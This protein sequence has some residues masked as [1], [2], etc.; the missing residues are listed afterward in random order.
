MSYT[1][2]DTDMDKYDDLEELYKLERVGIK[3]GLDRIKRLLNKLGNPQDHYKIVHVGGTNGKGS[4]CRAISSILLEG[5]YSVGLYTSPHLVRLNER[6]VVDGKEIENDEL[7]DISRKV[8]GIVRDMYEKPTFFEITTAIAFEFFRMKEID[9]AVVEVGM[10]G[11][12]DATNVVSPTL[13]IIT[14]VAIDH[15]DYLGNS[16]ED[17]AR[18][19]AGIIKCGI[20]VITSAKGK[21]LDIIRS[22][23]RS[24]DAELITVDGRWKRT[25]FDIVCQR[26][27]VNGILRDYELESR[28]LG[29]FQGENIALSVLAAEKLQM[30]G[31]FLPDKSIEAGIKNTLNPGRMEFISRSP[32][33][34]IDGAHNV[35][36][37]D[38]LTKSLKDFSYN[39]LIVVLGILRDKDI[40]G[41]VKKISHL[42]EHII[43]TMPNSERAFDSEKLAE[44]VRR[45]N[46]KCEVHVTR[47]V[48]DA[49]EMAKRICKN[50][51]LICVTGSL[52]TV[53]EV[54]ATIIS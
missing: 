37:M 22:V 48:K 43:T 47:N 50:D 9:I 23:A 49:I 51:D 2:R 33:I 34:L 1:V 41:M 46:P 11:R 28:M 54:R 52:Y 31:L 44:V 36:G 12:Y 32:R 18:E 16:I 30:M 35:D 7:L 15:T 39:N 3:L 17:I 25:G 29:I 27:I 42:A 6:F 20:P 5:G 45:C 38:A 24:K 40:E 14:N 8:L 53:G 26:F 21:A 13:C 4:V 10:G 19:K